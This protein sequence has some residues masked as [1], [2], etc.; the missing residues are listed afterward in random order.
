VTTAR[1]RRVWRAAA[2]ATL[3]AVGLVSPH[4]TGHDEARADRAGGE[5]ALA[6]GPVDAGAERPAPCPLC[7]AGAKVRDPLPR[8]A[9]L[10][11]PLPGAELPLAPRAAGRAPRDARGEPAAPRAP[12]IG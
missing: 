3:L 7:L 12:P 6:A 5:L 9:V 10:A 4:L 8:A 1:T 11:L 2:L